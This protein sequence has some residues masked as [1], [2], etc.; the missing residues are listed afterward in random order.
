MV[1]RAECKSA[2]HEKNSS[3]SK[4]N[5]VR[6]VTGCYFSEAL[7][8]YRFVLLDEIGEIRVFGSEFFRQSSLMCFKQKFY[9][10]RKVAL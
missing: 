8:L 1:A 3:P 9:S 4:T 2:R 10:A 5:T 6:K 7:S